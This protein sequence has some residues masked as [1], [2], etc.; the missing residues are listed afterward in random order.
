MQRL[1]AL[2]VVFLLAIGIALSRWVSLPVVILIP[3]TIVVLILAII[4][5]KQKVS[6]WLLV[7]T[8]ISSGFLSYRTSLPLNNFTP[9][10]TQI[11]GIVLEPPIIRRDRTYFPIL[12][13]ETLDNT[14]YHTINGK[15]W[16]TYTSRCSDLRQG[17]KVAVAGI[18]FPNRPQR[19]PGDFNTKAWRER[20]GFFGTINSFESDDLKI[21]SRRQSLVYLVREKI[22]RTTEEYFGENAPLLRALLLGIRR[23]VDPELVDDLRVTGLSHLL[24]LSGLHIGFLIGILIGIGALM[25][26]T[27]AWRSG[28]A[29][30]GIFLFLLLVPPRGCTLRAGIMAAVFLSGPIIKRWSPPINCLAFA[31]LVILCIRPGDLFDAGFQM[32]FA[33]IGGI[34]LFFPYLDKVRI[35]L[36]AHKK[37]SLRLVSVYF[38]QP[39]LISCAAC[40]LVIPLTSYY[41]GMMA[42]SSPVFN[43]FAVP[44]LGFIFAG[45][46]LVI[47]LSFVMP[48]LANVAAD[49]VN[50]SIAAFKWITHFFSTQASVGYERLAP[51]TVFL[52]I[53]SLIWLAVSRRKARIRLLACPLVILIAITWD[54]LI[55]ISSRLQAWFLD[56]GHGDAQ[57][58]LFP[59]DRTVI[60]DGGPDHQPSNYKGAIPKLLDYYD[61]KKI[62]LM[63]A[64]HPE[65]DHIG[66]LIELVEEYPV[67]LAITG[68]AINDTKTY[69]R[70]SSASQKND[71]R[72]QKLSDGNYISGLSE[73]YHLTVVGPPA[74]AE[75]WSKNDASLVLL[76]EITM[77]SDQTLRLLTTGD[78]EKKGE[79]ALVARGGIRAQLLKVPH[80]G[81]K[82][83][84][85]PEFIAAVKPDKAVITRPGRWEKSKYQHTNEVIERL[86]ADGIRI[87]QTGQIGAI[88]CEPAVVKGKTEWTVVDWRNPFFLRWFFGSI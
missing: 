5:D 80:H 56:V 62:D 59:Y 65:C 63:V 39:F 31:A 46:W 42:F 77:D 81:S 43:I 14:D 88:L 24:A 51:I 28:L 76:L 9:V 72:W 25:R 86:K 21:L 36:K 84:S 3:F 45:A 41:F 73:K 13:S 74:G 6:Q 4:T 54:G 61:R 47:G 64:T 20:N 30:I 11:T 40:C 50:G 55:P 57:V 75:K 49:G 87:L 71:I 85:S 10:K 22:I 38:A 35:A 8:L 12:C 52:I 70:L 26:F 79:R 23:D 34:I 16:V 29:I 83:S 17:M 68:P 48:G 53:I 37:R 1:P 58:W 15:I 67:G 60:I 82:T 2:K 27:P 32:S 78:V 18:L 44:L 69:L 19:N 66:G 33:A 7:T